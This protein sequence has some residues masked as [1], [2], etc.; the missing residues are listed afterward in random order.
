MKLEDMPT[1]ALLAMHNE[2]A[3]KSAGPKS[4]KTKTDLIARIRK[5]QPPQIAP[6]QPSMP[7]KTKAEPTR[8]A[9]VASATDAPKKPRGSGVGERAKQLILTTALPYDAIAARI[10]AE[11]YGATAT[12]ASVGWYAS[13]MRKDGVEVPPRA[14]KEN[15]DAT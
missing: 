4:F 9:E 14:P 5:L 6:R 1:K 8:K 15:V 11:I 7:E 12:K 2:L 3:D 10:N 13:K